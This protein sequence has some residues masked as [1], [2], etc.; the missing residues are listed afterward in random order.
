MKQTEEDTLTI[1]LSY[2]YHAQSDIKKHAIKV[3]RTCRIVRDRTKDKILYSACK[4][5]INAVSI[6]RYEKALQA[7]ELTYIKYKE[8]YLN[9]KHV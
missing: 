6:G 7:L 9:S 8:L 4:Q 3:S 2:A 1:L 5:V